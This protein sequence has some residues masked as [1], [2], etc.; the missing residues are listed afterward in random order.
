MWK[1]NIFST[2]QAQNPVRTSY[3]RPG[4]D[5]NSAGRPASTADATGVAARDPGR[6]ANRQQREEMKGPLLHT[7]IGGDNQQQK[8]W[9]KHISGNVLEIIGD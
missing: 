1:P 9:A 6:R 2:R 4:L 7:Q 3:S 5:A 8:L